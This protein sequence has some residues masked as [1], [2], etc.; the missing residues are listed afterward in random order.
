MDLTQIR[1]F[2]ALARTLNFTRAAE[3]CNVTQPALTKSIQRLE[4]ELG[5]PLL[6]RERSLTQLTVLGRTV[7]PMLEQTYKAAEGAKQLASEMKRQTASP[8]RIGF[9]PDAPAPPFRPVFAEIAARLPA[10]QLDIVDADN[11]RLCDALLHGTLDVAIVTRGVDLPD[12][13]NR[14]TIFTDTIVMVMPD[15]HELATQNAVKLTALDGINVVC[16]TLNCGMARL[17]E[18]AQS[19]GINPAARHQADTVERVMDLVRGGLGIACSTELTSLPTGL[20][21][22]PL[23]GAANHDVVL[24]A[25]AGRPFSRAADAFVKLTRARQWP[26]GIQAGLSPA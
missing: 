26:T 5:G 14:W 9:A 23:E 12:R 3:A 4:E 15:D 10:F 20:R 2:L 1:Y 7:L 25:V 22:R 8:L 6:L 11:D 16:R 21:K 18:Q 13:L 19:D 17:L 24:V